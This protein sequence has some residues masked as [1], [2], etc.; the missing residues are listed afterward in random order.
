MTGP[1]PQTLR[2]LRAVLQAFDDGAGTLHEVG[3][4]T[5]LDPDVVR[6]AVDHLVRAGYLDAS[7][8]AVGCPSGGCSS[9]AS[10]VDDAPGCGASGSSVGRAGPVLVALTPTRR[11]RPF[12]HGQGTSGG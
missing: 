8:L 9:C 5:G 6:A 10:G 3:V 11:Y 2:P 12:G 4:R 7:E 1:E